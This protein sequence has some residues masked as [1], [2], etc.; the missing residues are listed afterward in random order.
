MYRWIEKW[1]IS[2]ETAR[3]VTY[4]FCYKQAYRLKQ[5][6][7]HTE[8]KFYNKAFSLHIFFL[9]FFLSS[10][11]Y[12]FFLWGRRSPNTINL[13]SFISSP[14]RTAP[15]FMHREHSLVD[16]QIDWSRGFLIRA[17]GCMQFGC[18]T[19]DVVEVNL[20]YIKFATKL[21]NKATLFPSGKKT[22]TENWL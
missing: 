17:L 21:I 10:F 7:M 18:K 13:N 22:I 4:C 19:G 14:N 20:C 11:L 3:N 5:N 1:Q 12:Y 6:K 15:S 8:P 9:S 2:R 16:S